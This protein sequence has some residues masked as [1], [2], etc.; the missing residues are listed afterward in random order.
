MTWEDDHPH[1]GTMGA[2]GEKGLFSGGRA[3][4]T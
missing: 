3:P 2:D 4:V 1:A